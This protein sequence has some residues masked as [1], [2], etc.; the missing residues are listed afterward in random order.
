MA[1]SRRHPPHAVPQTALLARSTAVSKDETADVL[2][3]TAHIPVGERA[4]ARREDFSGQS[5][6]F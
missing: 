5:K 4:L 6:F 1:I 3:R 2:G